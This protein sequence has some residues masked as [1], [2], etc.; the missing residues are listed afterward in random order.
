[1]K[2]HVLRKSIRVVCFAEAKEVGNHSSLIHS[3]MRTYDIF[4]F[5]FNPISESAKICSFKNMGF[6]YNSILTSFEIW[7]QLTNF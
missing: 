6:S 1:M 4:Y 3:T 5:L 2:K 7:V